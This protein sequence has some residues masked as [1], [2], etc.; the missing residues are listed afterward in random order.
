MNWIELTKDRLGIFCVHNDE[1]EA[2]DLYN[3]EMFQNVFYP[4]LIQFFLLWAA[5]HS[6]VGT[7]SEKEN[8]NN[9]KLV[10]YNRSVIYS[11]TYCLN[12]IILHNLLHQ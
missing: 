2:R 9:N 8:N 10:Q 4:A 11:F 3:Y 6:S 7:E 5:L 12:I 1:L